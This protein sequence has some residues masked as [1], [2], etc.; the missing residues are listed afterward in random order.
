MKQIGGRTDCSHRNFRLDTETYV[1]I[2][3]RVNS[4]TW[5]WCDFCVEDVIN[6]ARRTLK[7]TVLACATAALT[8]AMPL[9][10]ATAQP[11]PVS[12][13]AGSSTGD[14]LAGTV[15]AIRAHNHAVGQALPTDNL[16]RPNAQAL[17]AAEAFAHQPWV[18]ADMRSAIL[19]A[20]EFFR[21]T[22]PSESSVAL[23]TDGPAITQFYWPSIAGRCIGG[24][25]ASVGTAIAVP[26]PAE[27]PAPGAAA[28]EAAFL[29]TAL[30]TQPATPEQGG[31]TVQWFNLN[32]LRHGSV[33][34]ENNGVNPDGPATVSATAPTGTGTVVALLRG[35][36]NTQD[37]P[38][39]YFPT[40][41]IVDVR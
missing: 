31:M 12:S 30:G 10:A 29:F 8:M 22:P 4:V 15:N 28:G 11:V 26:G 6:V 9:A 2:V 37:G 33:S 20:V 32:T 16:G 3:I 23:P 38:C 21:T 7:R 34:L 13:A 1:A 17:A 14:A 25:H 27:I 5:H 18:P 24:E 19:A 36:V 41:T 39:T 40:A 35:T